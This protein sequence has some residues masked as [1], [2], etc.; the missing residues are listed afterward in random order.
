MTRLRSIWTTMRNNFELIA[1]R[2]RKKIPVIGFFT[3]QSLIVLVFGVA[4]LFSLELEPILT[5]TASVITAVSFLGLGSLFVFT[6][7]NA[8]RNENYLIG[9]IFLAGTIHALT[10]I[11]LMMLPHFI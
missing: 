3:F 5:P 8:I 6:I 10:F 4:L 7:R 1:E 2:I 11:T 9:D